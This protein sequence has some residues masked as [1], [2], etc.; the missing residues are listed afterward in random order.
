MFD[1][2]LHIHSSS[3]KFIRWVYISVFSI[4]LC[5]SILLTCSMSFVLAYSIVALKCL[6]DLKFI[7]NNLGFCSSSAIR[8]LLR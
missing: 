8:L 3:L 2:I 7:I 1:A 4:R 6:R 5:P